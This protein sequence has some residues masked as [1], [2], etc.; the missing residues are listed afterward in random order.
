MCFSVLPNGISSIFKLFMPITIC[1]HVCKN[2]LESAKFY[3]SI[4]LFNNIPTLL[5]EVY[6]TYGN[7]IRI[8]NEYYTKV[9]G[10][11]HLQHVSHIC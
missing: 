5:Q 8:R 11:G 7:I 6:E 1:C 2:A 4:I 9:N 3:F 10:C